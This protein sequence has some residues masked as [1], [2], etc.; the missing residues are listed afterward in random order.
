MIAVT[1]AVCLVREN[2]YIPTKY[3]LFQIL[4]RKHLKTE[5]YRGSDDR[6]EVDLDSYINRLASGNLRQSTTVT[7]KREK[8]T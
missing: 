1:S 4:H 7:S 5:H 8:F 2:I 6:G 3:T